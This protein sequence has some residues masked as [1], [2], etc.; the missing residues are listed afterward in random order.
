M[1]TICINHDDNAEK[2]AQVAIMGDVYGAVSEVLAC[3][4][5]ADEASQQVYRYTQALA[6][7]VTG[8]EGLLE[9][10]GMIWEFFD[11]VE[12]AIDFWKRWGLDQGPPVV[13]ELCERYVQFCKRPF[14]RRLWILQEL[15]EGGADTLLLAGKHILRLRDMRPLSL[16]IKYCFQ[17][18][19]FKGVAQRGDEGNAFDLPYSA[20]RRR[21]DFDEAM[22]MYSTFLCKNPR[23][24]SFGTLRIIDWSDD[25]PP[26]PDYEISRFDLALSLISKATRIEY[27]NSV[28]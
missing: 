28:P 23:D 12:I 24:R 22:S 13:R 4:G 21:W 17:N 11:D 1:D 8:L 20:V 15:F 16:A 6:K 18:P 9:H 5:P 26:R 7:P 10:R 2:S 3:I 14:L 27:S 19:P 25:S